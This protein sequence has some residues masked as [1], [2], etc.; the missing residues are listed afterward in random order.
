[1]TV[2]CVRHLSGHGSSTG[3]WILHVNRRK[4][5]VGMSRVRRHL[6]IVIIAARALN[7]SISNPVNSRLRDLFCTNLVIGD[8]LYL[9]SSRK[10]NHKKRKRK[11]VVVAFETLEFEMNSK[12]TRHSAA[13]QCAANS[14]WTEF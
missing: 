7:V 4:V 1:M 12:M 5:A 9:I 13:S 8:F 14:H 2:S 6:Q 3:T 11:M 10:K